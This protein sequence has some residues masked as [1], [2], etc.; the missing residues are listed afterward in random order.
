MDRAVR[1]DLER[2]VGHDHGVRDA[3]NVVDV[4]RAVEGE[5]ADL[6]VASVSLALMASRREARELVVGRDAIDAFIVDAASNVVAEQREDRQ[7]ARQQ[8]GERVIQG[9][10]ERGHDGGP[11]ARAGAAERIL[12]IRRVIF[13][14]RRRGRRGH[15]LHLDGLGLCLV[16]KLD[17]G[18]QPRR[19]LLRRGR[20]ATGESLAQSCPAGARLAPRL[21]FA[22]RLGEM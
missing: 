16:A 9:A 17:S 21:G 1:E 10:A 2:E 11:R 5:D 15:R 8:L 3:K 4:G 12:T 7:Q 6:R 13:T 20:G 18:G 19:A 14:I 22:T